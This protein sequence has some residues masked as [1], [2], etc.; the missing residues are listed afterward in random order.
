[1]EKERQRLR[2]AIVCIHGELVPGHPLDTQI[3]M[4]IPFT[5]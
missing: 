1:M 4:L 3:Q 5:E 2:K